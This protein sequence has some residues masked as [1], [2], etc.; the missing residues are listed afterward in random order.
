MTTR[1]KI[2]LGM[3]VVAVG[4]TIPLFFQYQQISHLQADLDKASAKFAS[5]RKSAALAGRQAPNQSSLKQL[6]SMHNRLDS[7]RGLFDLADSLDAAGA[8]RC[9]KNWPRNR[10]LA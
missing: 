3:L 1:G 7:I 5:A 8:A 6:L 9:W 2:I 10:S 4:A